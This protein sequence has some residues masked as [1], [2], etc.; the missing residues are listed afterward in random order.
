MN[1]QGFR[2]FFLLALLIMAISSFPF[3][4]LPP[5][6]PKTAVSIQDILNWFGARRHINEIVSMFGRGME[7]HIVTAFWPIYMFLIAG[8][9]G[10]QGFSAS[11]SL[12]LGSIAIYLSGKYMDREGNRKRLLFGSI[13]TSVV[14]PIRG[15]VK[16]FNELLVVDSLMAIISP[17]YWINFE[18][19][20]YKDAK[21]RSENGLLFMTA[22]LFITS[23]A[24]LVVLLVALLLAGSEYKFTGLI[25]LAALGSLMSY[26]IWESR[27]IKQ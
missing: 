26:F 5:H 19:L 21:I 27:K 9:Y 15:L 2:P 1:T 12:L 6:K 18:S 4:L 13:G 17:F 3:F 14:W 24:F 11:L 22:K 7:E 16:T 10:R 20:V 23:F 25:I 8:A